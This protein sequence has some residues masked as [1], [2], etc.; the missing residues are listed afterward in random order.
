MSILVIVEHDNSSLKPATLN[1][2]AAA[3]AIGASVH[4]LVAG[5]SCQSVA[6]EC[7]AV[8]GVEKVL[9]ADNVAYE[10]QLSEIIERALSEFDS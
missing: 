1:T 5:S 8:E 10:N 4:L 2:I 6:D 3:H 7:S 9:L